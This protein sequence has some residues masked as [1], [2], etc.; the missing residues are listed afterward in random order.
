MASRAFSRIQTLGNARVILSGSFQPNGANAA[1]L[2][3]KG[4]GF[5]VA[6]TPGG[7]LYTVTL[8]DSYPDY[9]FVGIDVQGPTQLTAQLAAEPDVKVAKTLVLALYN[10]SGAVNDAAFNANQRVH[11]QAVLKNTSGNF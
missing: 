2:G 8:Q 4:V 7:N 10:N 1:V 6:H 11:F 9:D 5:S 3:I